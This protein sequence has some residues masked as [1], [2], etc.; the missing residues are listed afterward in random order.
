MWQ[1][2]GANAF[3]PRSYPEESMRISKNWRLP[4][5]LCA[6]L[7][8][9]VIVLVVAGAQGGPAKA[10]PHAAGKV[11]VPA[12]ASEVTYCRTCHAD[13]CSVPHP[14]LVRLTWP[15]RGRVV[16]GVQGEVTCG[17]CH[18]RGF[19]HRSDAF[20]ARDQKGL[21]NQCHYDAHALSN[22]HESG[23]RCED[24]HTRAKDVLAH[25]SPVET[26]AMRTDVDAECLRCHYDG[27]VTH[28]ISVPN[29]KKKAPDL[30]LSSDGKITCVTCHVGHH[31]RD[32]FGVMLRK[33]NRH[34]GLCLSCHDDL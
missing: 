22:A 31:D 32:R 6:G 34:G 29:T 33:D 30:P 4:M 12:G 3:E 27:P 23:Q 28:P 17:T 11:S 5:A 14:E 18:T 13:G 1:R 8:L 21:C 20:L 10:D 19:R 25:A 9:S 24:C 2:L 7:L 15:A 26:H 16:L